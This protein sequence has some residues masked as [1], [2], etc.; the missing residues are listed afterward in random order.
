M[1]LTYPLDGSEETM[2]RILS[3]TVVLWIA[4]PGRA[5]GQTS[6]RDLYV[7]KC[8]ACH[9]LNG[10]GE[11]TIGRS[12]GLGDVRPGIKSRTDEQ[13]RQIVRQGTGKMP[14][15]KKLDD[16]QLGSLTLFLRDLVDGNPNAGR[17]VVQDQAQP[18]ANVEQVFRDKCSACHG[19]D[20]SGQ[21]SIG[22]RDKIPGLTSLSVQ[23]RNDSQLQDIVSNGA[24]R[25]PGYKKSF[26]PTQV[27]QF[28][29]YIRGLAALPTPSQRTAKVETAIP[30]GKSEG[31]SH[32]LSAP[33]VVTASDAVSAP[34][35]VKAPSVLKAPPVVTAQPVAETK[36]P[37]VPVA[38]PAAKAKASG[39]GH[40]IYSAKCS[41]CHARR[42]WHGYRRQEHGSPQSDFAA[43]AGSQRRKPCAYHRKRTANPS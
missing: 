27:S 12:L 22:K 43:S 23:N 33:L 17:A 2:R 6:G 11:S 30:S 14:G 5:S 40:D 28:V 16:E 21:T 1:D 15:N 13:L 39:T 34:P 29:S 41:A 26:N 25:M 8:S 38:T 24:G 35:V 4:F 19:R 3:L 18:L 32:P 9:A 20:G 36:A 7:A 37:P 42:H 10:S 31:D